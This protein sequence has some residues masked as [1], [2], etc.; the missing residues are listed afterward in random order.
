MKEEEPN[1]KTNF[2][3]NLEE[4]SSRKPAQH[5]TSTRP[6]CGPCMPVNR[7][8]FEQSAAGIPS[9]PM[10]P[11]IK[12]LP[13]TQCCRLRV[14]CAAHLPHS[15]QGLPEVPLRRLPFPPPVQPP[16][17]I[18]LPPARPDSCGCT[19]FR[20]LLET[21]GEAQARPPNCE[22]HRQRSSAPRRSLSSC[23]EHCCNVEPNPDSEGF[24][25]CGDFS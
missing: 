16:E 15:H 13:L 21:S 3:C 8:A 14:R 12:Q 9:P 24:L 1:T 2:L 7:E 25:H 5:Q 6:V 22:T 11:G 10:C 19:A 20:K 17:S 23:R 18:Y 4:A